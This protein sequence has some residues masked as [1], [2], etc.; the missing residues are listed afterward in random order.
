MP[1]I[2]VQ[3]VAGMEYHSQNQAKELTLILFMDA[4]AVL[5]CQNPRSMSLQ[6]DCCVSQNDAAANSELTRYHTIFI[7]WKQRQLQ[8]KL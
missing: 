3:D 8:Y 6:V 7:D 2:L 1:I 4:G 5:V